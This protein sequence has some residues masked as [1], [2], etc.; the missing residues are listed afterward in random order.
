MVYTGQSN[1]GKATAVQDE[2]NMPYAHPPGEGGPM[3]PKPGHS[4]WRRTGPEGSR[5]P[6]QLHKDTS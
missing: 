5:Y 3:G 1:T 2:C 6:R 4:P